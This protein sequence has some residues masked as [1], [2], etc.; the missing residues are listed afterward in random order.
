MKEKIIVIGAGPGG[1]VAALR[2]ASLGAD[3]TIIERQHVGGTCLNHG[4]IPSKILKTSADLFLSFQRSSEFGIIN[5]GDTYVDMTAMMLRKQKIIET[6]RKGINNLLKKSHIVFERGRGVIKKKGIVSLMSDNGEMIKDIL[7]DKLIL[8][9]GTIPMNVLA[10][11]FDGKKI[12]SSDHVLELTELPKSMIIVGGGVIGCEFAFIFSELGV[13]ITLVEA[14]S[15]LLPLPSVDD[16]CSKI[17]QREMKKKK[18]KFYTDRAVTGVDIKQDSVCVTIG[19][20]PFLD[21]EKQEKVTPISVEAEKMAICIGRTPLTNDMGL[22][23]IG[24]GTDEKGWIKVNDKMETDASGVYAIGDI[25][26]PSRVMLAHVASHEGMIA[27]E[28]ALGGNKKMDYNAVPG[29]IFTTPEIGNVGMS[30]A[31]AKSKGIEIECFSVN[32]RNLGKAQAMG[33]IAGEAKIVV[34]KQSGKVLGVHIIGPHA[35][36]LIAEGALIVNKGLFVSDIAETIHAHPTLAE[37][38]SEVSLKAAGMAVHG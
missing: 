8:A 7:F 26:G 13:E 29:A 16:S 24:L 33:E 5:N 9:M 23:N 17:L 4:C 19:A 10:F 6:Q 30:E 34:E 2:A 22:D 38:M 27:A 25:L 28:N 37:I 35:T 11:P 21:A 36:D 20:S 14:M 1:Y 18:I 31:G 3:V 32:F 12:L 15:R